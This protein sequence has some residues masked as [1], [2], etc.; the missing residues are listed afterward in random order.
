VSGE[1]PGHLAAAPYSLRP[2]L[3]PL[4]VVVLLGVLNGLIYRG[5][6]TFLPTHLS[7][8]VHL[9]AAGIDS[10]MLA[11]SFTTVALLFGVAGQ[12]LGGYLSDRR[13]REKLALLATAISVPALAA[14]WG[15]GGLLLL[16]SAAL[17]AFFH[18]MSQPV[19]NALVADYSPDLWR[20]RVYGVYFFCAFGVGSFSAG[21]LGYAAE[22]HGVETVFLICAAIGALATLCTVL[23]VLKTRGRRM[24]DKMP[25]AA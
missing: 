18:F 20:G 9:G 24:G 23:L 12:F 15:F 25:E 17:F 22:Q 4:V 11:G 5:V 10:V 16:G 8:N 21:P 14:V 6:V 3:A 1:A 7:E 2:F 13:S 19:F